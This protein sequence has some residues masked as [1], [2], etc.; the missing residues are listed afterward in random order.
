MTDFI[1]LQMQNFD[2]SDNEK[3]ANIEKYAIF[4]RSPLELNMFV[5]IKNGQKVKHSDE[6]A[7]DQICFAAND[8]LIDSNNNVSY[9]KHNNAMI[10]NIGANGFWYEIVA[11]LVP[12]NITLTEKCQKA[13]NQI[14]M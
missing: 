11:D 12:L 10:W 4:L 14:M 7:S 1:L 6:D 9:I 8:I 2:L 13:W 5:P 3:I